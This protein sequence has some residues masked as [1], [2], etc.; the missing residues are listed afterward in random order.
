MAISTGVKLASNVHNDI[1]PYSP[2]IFNTALLPSGDTNPV[3]RVFTVTNTP[4]RLIAYGLFSGKVMVSRVQLPDTETSFNECGDINSA[5][6]LHE[7]SYKVGCK[8]VMLCPEQDELVIDAVGTYRLH[9]V[10][11]DRASIHVVHKQEPVTTITNN[12]RGI[13]GCCNE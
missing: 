8:G 9:Y 6:V 4:I 11:D 13:E 3:S 2:K 5:G 1:D 7:K 12:V 10:G